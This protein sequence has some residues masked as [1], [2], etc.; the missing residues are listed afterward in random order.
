MFGFDALTEAID[1]DRKERLAYP[2]LRYL[3]Q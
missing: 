3:M 2:K 1:D